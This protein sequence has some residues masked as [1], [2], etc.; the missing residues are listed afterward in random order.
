MGRVTTV[1]GFDSW[2]R[3]FHMPQAQPNTKTKTK[4]QEPDNA[5]VSRNSHTDHSPKRFTSTHSLPPA[6]QRTEGAWWS[7]PAAGT[8][9][10]LMLGPAHPPR[11]P[12]GSA[13]PCPHTWVQ[14]P[15]GWPPCQQHLPCNLAL[16]SQ[17]ANLPTLIPP[18]Y[19]G[20]RGLNS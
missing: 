9:G 5:G 19:S 17:H 15:S 20:F 14:R 8:Q 12:P 10:V 11:G 13:L 2:S 1:A 3:N 18:G 7:P 16:K 6:Q 4:P